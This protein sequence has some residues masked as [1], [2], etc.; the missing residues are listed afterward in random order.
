[1]LA[2]SLRRTS[3]AELGEIL[4]AWFGGTSS[5]DLSDVENI[6]HLREIERPG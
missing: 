3:Q 6:A 1:V 5:A 2:L 4:D